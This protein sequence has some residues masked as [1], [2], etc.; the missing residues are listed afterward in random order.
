MLCFWHN[1][2]ECFPLGCIGPCLR[3]S[4]RKLRGHLFKK[5]LLLLHMGGTTLRLRAG[6]HGSQVP[7]PSR[8]ICAILA[9]GSM[10]VGTYHF[11]WGFKSHVWHGCL[12]GNTFE[13]WCLG[14][15]MLNL[16]C[17]ELG[18]SKKLVP[19]LN[20]IILAN[21]VCTLK[22]EARNKSNSIQNQIML[23]SQHSKFNLINSSEAMLLLIL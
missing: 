4:K 22:S 5:P 3:W 19:T 21:W 17:W 8:S 7:S 16:L 23:F 20:S 6:S 18:H 2:L 12:H 15:A 14:L 11:T 1:N 13:Q 10:E 9:V